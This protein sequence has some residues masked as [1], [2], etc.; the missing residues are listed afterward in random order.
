VPHDIPAWVGAACAVT[1][2]LLAIRPL[3]WAFKLLIGTHEFVTEWPRVRAAIAELQEEVAHIKAET[4]PN[5]GNSLHDILRRTAEDVSDI[6][7]EQERLRA[8]I[9]L[10]Q[11]PER[12]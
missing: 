7:H 9:E 3:H 6:K 10:R 2:I 11:P 4:M 1:G 5:G 12:M 8:E